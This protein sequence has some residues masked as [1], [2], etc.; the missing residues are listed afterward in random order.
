MKTTPSRYVL[1][2]EILTIILLHVVKIRQAEKH[3]ADMA[4]N[5]TVKNMP[6]IKP[7]KENKPGAEFMLVNLVK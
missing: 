4:F 2:V 3:P 1:A 5:P 7:V 6:I